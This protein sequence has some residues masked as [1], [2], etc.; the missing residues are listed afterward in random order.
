MEIKE[1]IIEKIES[2]KRKE[3][4]EEVVEKWKIEYLP[5]WNIE[6]IADHYIV[7]SAIE[8]RKHLG[9][10]LNCK[11]VK[12]GISAIFTITRKKVFMRK[13]SSDCKR[14]GCWI[15]EENWFSILKHGR[16]GWSEST[17]C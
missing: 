14:G 8:H 1:W 3:R 9:T 17:Y 16:C 12:D 15:H 7:Q 4:E 13:T 6:N 5:Q 2:E 11:I 10:D